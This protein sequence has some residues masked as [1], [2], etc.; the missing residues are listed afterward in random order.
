MG[1]PKEDQVQIAQLLGYSVSGFG[2]LSYVPKKLVRECD[3]I[4]DKIA[5]QGRRSR[6]GKSEKP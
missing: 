6:V 3:D 5:N 2:Y 1:F 4:A